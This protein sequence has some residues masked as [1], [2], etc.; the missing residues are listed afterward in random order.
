MLNCRMGILQSF[1]CTRDCFLICSLLGVLLRWHETRV[2]TVG[3]TWPA[4]LPEFPTDPSSCED[5][6]LLPTY[7][8]RFR[9]R[10]AW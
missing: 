9:L 5:T 2:L 4:C 8:F 10:A 3:P 1:K 6:A 7:Q